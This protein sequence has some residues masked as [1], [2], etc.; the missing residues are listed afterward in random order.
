M[1]LET[2]ANLSHSLEV[3]SFSWREGKGREGG[4]EK[5]KEMERGREGR[6][7]GKEGRGI[8]ERGKGRK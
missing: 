2:R 7:G 6:R 5:E 4:R 8:G 3:S 1:R